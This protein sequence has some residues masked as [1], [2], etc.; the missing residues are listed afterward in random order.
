[1]D[2]IELEEP[3]E[4]RLLDEEIRVQHREDVP[5]R[6]WLNASNAW[7]MLL[8]LMGIT[9][10]YLAFQLD[11]ARALKGPFRIAEDVNRIVPRC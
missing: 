4:E 3:E 5:R 6:R 10:A 9:I 11:K 8:V 1:M 2:V 7:W